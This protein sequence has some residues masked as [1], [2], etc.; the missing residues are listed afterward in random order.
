MYMYLLINFSAIHFTKTNL[1]KVAPLYPCGIPSF[2]RKVRREFN[3]YVY[4]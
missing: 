1:W 3:L 4:M 2:L